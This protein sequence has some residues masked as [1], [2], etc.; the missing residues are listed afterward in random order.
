LNEN[1]ISD[2]VITFTIGQVMI[3]KTLTQSSTKILIVRFCAIALHLWS[4]PNF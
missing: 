4:C 2:L 3:T 1:A